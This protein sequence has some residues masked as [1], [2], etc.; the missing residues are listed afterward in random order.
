M[1]GREHLSEPRHL[2][3]DALL[4]AIYGIASQD[5]EA[6][7][8]ACPDC[9]ARWSEWRHKRAIPA[10]EPSSD[11]LA[12]QR[13][14]IY[15]RIEVKPSRKRLWAPVFAAACALAVGVFVYHPNSAAPPVATAEP[16]DAQLFADVYSLE[17]SVEPAATAPVRGL[18][19]EGQ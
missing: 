7:L 10:N 16:G 17:Q 9:A 6:H 19:E 14:E 3:Q 4:D 12:A 8:R 2:S 1:S 15:R 5:A 13:R 18:F 11:F